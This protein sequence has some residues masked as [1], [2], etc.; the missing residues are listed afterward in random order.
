[1]R[2]TDYIVEDFVLDGSFQNWAL[3][4]N[5]RDEAFWEQWI[6]AHPEMQPVV[7]EAREIVQGLQS[8]E[9]EVS[10][11][12]IDEQ[13]REVTAFFDQ[14]MKSEQKKVRAL[15]PIVKI[16]ATI[17]VLTGL[18]AAAYYY[19]ASPFDSGPKD[20]PAKVAELPQIQSSD[21]KA[22]RSEESN[23]TDSLE[24][25]NP[26]KPGPTDEKAGSKGQT[27]V[28]QTQETPGQI[29]QEDKTE[30]TR[31]TTSAG[32]KRKITLPDGSRVFMNENSRLAVS[33]DWAKDQTRKVRL[34]GEAYFKVEEKI[35]RGSKVKFVVSTNSLDVEVVGTAFDVNAA[36]Q[37]T[38]VYLNSGKVQLR[39]HGKQGS[40]DMS[41]GEMVE[42]NASTGG[43]NT[44][45]TSSPSLLSW[46][47]SFGEPVNAPGTPDNMT[48]N[49]QVEASNNRG[50]VL[51]SGK[52]NSAY[53]EQ[54]GENIK[55]RQQ[56]QGRDNEARA[57]VTGQSGSDDANWSTWQLQQGEDNVSIFNIVQSYNSNLYSM[58]QGQQ[59][60][61]SGES[62][63]RDNTGIM[64]Q[65]GRQNEALL[66]QQGKDNEALIIQ[67]GPGGK[68]MNDKGFIQDLMEGRYNKVNIIQ[69]GYNNQARTIQQGRNNQ[70]EVNQQ[71][72]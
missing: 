40:I 11:E 1:M 67:K 59:N 57:V 30:T 45:R 14:Q 68:A 55:S 61:A 72:K 63:G 16:A 66:L 65:Q 18:G 28:S 22:N 47:E 10:R 9:V 70:V 37:K 50:Q 12:E 35:H 58:Q 32:E 27:R 60:I 17:L 41:P 4:R 8:D 44:R 64:L 31:Y 25:R 3:G 51:Q 38:Q 69:Q 43:L 5:S 71:G 36:N 2:Y 13:F 26:L 42:Y 19:V 29:T 62:R 39:I 20:N 15:H 21:K 49:T 23:P 6:A 34:E 33:A 53:I 54:V 48:L 52:E 24:F 7:D 46:M 56:Q